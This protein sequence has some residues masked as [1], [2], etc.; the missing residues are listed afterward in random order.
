MSTRSKQFRSLEADYDGRW[1]RLSVDVIDDI[2]AH[3]HQP[4]E[5]VLTDIDAAYPFTRREHYPYKAW[6]EARKSARVVLGL[7]EPTAKQRRILEFWKSK[8]TK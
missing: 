5:Q 6:L 2:L 8:E 7:L 4:A 1:R 3:N